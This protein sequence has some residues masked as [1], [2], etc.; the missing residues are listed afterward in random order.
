MA[1]A[2]YAA[3]RSGAA[4]G[5]GADSLGSVRASCAAAAGGFPV[6]PVACLAP[7]HVAGYVSGL[8]R[9]R[10][11]RRP[12]VA[13]VAVRVRTAAKV[14]R[15]P[16]LPARA[17]Q[18]SRVVLVS[19]G[20]GGRLRTRVAGRRRAAPAL[21]VAHARCIRGIVSLFGAVSGPPRAGGHRAAPGECVRAPPVRPAAGRRSSHSAN[22]HSICR[23]AL[24]RPPDTP[25]AFPGRPRRAREGLRAGQA[26]S[27]RA[28]SLRRATAARDHGRQG[29]QASG[30]LPAR[31]RRRP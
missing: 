25:R 30:R 12:L 5:T 27:P 24:G 13:L 29:Q 21:A 26:G 22:H 31:V 19:A 17:A 7:A 1:A 15:R 3:P 6:R 4:P 18:V 9:F 28:P 11:A 16:A 8:K 10:S 20:P 14:A 2:R 23:R